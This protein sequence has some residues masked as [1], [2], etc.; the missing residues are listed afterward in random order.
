MRKEPHK[1]FNRYK[2]NK[3]LYYLS[4]EVILYDVCIEGVMC[5]SGIVIESDHDGFVGD[6][7]DPSDIW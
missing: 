3:E 2:M 6:Q 5:Q 1:I 7:G 4:P